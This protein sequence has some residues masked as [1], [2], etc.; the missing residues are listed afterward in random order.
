MTTASVD[1]INS[2]SLRARHTE[3]RF[4]SGFRRVVHRIHSPHLF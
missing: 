3:R 1:R 2:L 4:P